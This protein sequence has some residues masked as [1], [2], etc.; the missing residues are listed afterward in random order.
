MQIQSRIG[1]IRHLN[2]YLLCYSYFGC[3]ITKYRTKIDGLHNQKNLKNNQYPKTL[4]NAIYA[5]GG[6]KFD[7]EYY[8]T[9]K[10]WREKENKKKKDNDDKEIV[11]LSFAQMEGKCYCCGRAGH[12]SPQCKH[13][14]KPREEWAIHKANA[15]S[16]ESGSLNAQ[17]QQQENDERSTT[18]GSVR[19][20][21]N[22]GW[23]GAHVLKSGTMLTQGYQDE[24]RNALVLDS[25]SSVDLLCNPK[26]VTNITKSNKVLWLGTNGR[27][28][29]AN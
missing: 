24:L 2:N 28:A 9:R 13:K 16:K 7:K 23:N 27:E 4:D 21:S 19:E 26:M 29:T 17:Q 20:T 1:K 5:I 18:S 11:E 12:K 22:D 3:N 8:D 10:K 15:A 6:M 14:N 25:A